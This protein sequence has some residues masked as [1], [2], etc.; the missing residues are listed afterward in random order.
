MKDELIFIGEKLGEIELAVQS[1]PDFHDALLLSKKTPQKSLYQSIPL[2]TNTTVFI[3]FKES[4]IQFTYQQHSLIVEGEKGISEEEA[5]DIF[6]HFAI[7]EGK[8][9]AYLAHCPSKPQEGKK[10][11]VLAESVSRALNES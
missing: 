4:N 7:K 11:R 6:K 8:K 9:I 2:R 5:F 1:K 10:L 3:H